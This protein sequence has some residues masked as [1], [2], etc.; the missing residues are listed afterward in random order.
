MKA[1]GMIETRG[2]VAAIE[3]ADAAIKAADVSLVGYEKTK[4][5]GMILVKLKGDVGA[6]KA[7]VEAGV[8][9]ARKIGK[10]VSFHVIPRPHSD[11]DALVAVLDRSTGRL[12]PSPAAAPEPVCIEK[13]GLK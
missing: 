8:M 9:S 7:A 3:A 1:L 4:G 2:L 10:V 13:P 11:T 6:V 12:S 5:G